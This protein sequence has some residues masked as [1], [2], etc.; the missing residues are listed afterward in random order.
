M[1]TTWATERYH[2]TGPRPR[3]A[4]ADSSILDNVSIDEEEDANAMSLRRKHILPPI[5]PHKRGR[6]TSTDSLEEKLDNLFLPPG[7]V[8]EKT[9]QPER[10]KN[11]A[12]EFEQQQTTISPTHSV[13]QQRYSSAL[14]REMCPEIEWLAMPK[15]ESGGDNLT[16]DDFPQEWFNM[17]V[18]NRAK[19]FKARESG[20]HSLDG[21]EVSDLLNDDSWTSDMKSLVRDCF[22]AVYGTGD[23]ETASVRAGPSLV[24]KAFKGNWSGPAGWLNDE[25]VSAG[26]SERVIFP[27]YRAAVKLALDQMLIGEWEGKEEQITATATVLLT[28]ALR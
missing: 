6:R 1:Q 26:L 23:V 20:F 17:T 3:P 12:T 25:E 8:G 7:G 5:T 9:P 2:E 13:G 27:A 21:S 16:Q 18:A 28:P 19:I 11:P 10:K 24:V 14:G 4:S 22:I 15:A